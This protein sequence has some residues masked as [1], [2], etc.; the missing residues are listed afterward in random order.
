MI[1]KVGEQ[2][3]GTTSSAGHDDT[4]LTY[5]RTGD[6]APLICLPGG[7]MCAS[8]YLGDLGGLPAYRPLVRLDLRGTGDSATPADPASYRCD[9]QVDDVEAL[10]VHLGL[11]RID[12]LA[13]SAGANLAVAYGARHPDRIGRLVLVTP[14]PWAVALAITAEDR[15]AVTRSRRDQ[16]WYPRATAALDRVVAGAGSSEDWE[17]ITPF[18]YGRWDDTARAHAAATN[19]VRNA[20]AAAAWGAEGAFDPPVTRAA[21]ARLEAPALVLGGDR[22]INL[23]P[24]NAAAYAALFAHGRAVVQPGG[25][26]CPWLDDPARFTAEVASFLG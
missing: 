8:S 24:G 1:E 9:R 7:P 23:P 4:R 2:V 13:H 15:H 12:L 14:S 25:G 19:A 26:H 22:D 3:P 18:T 16:Q 20:D 11:D 6:G 10:R 21:L 5:H 17:A